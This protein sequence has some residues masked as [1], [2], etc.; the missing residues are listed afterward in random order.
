MQQLIKPSKLKPGDKVAAITLSWGGP[1]TFPYRFETGKQ[2][3]ES[4]FGLQV[5]PTKHALKSADWIYRN[6]KARAD[7]LMNAFLDPSIK[8]IISNNPKIF[9]GYSDTTVTHFMCLKAGLSSFYGPAVLTAFAENMVMH[10]YT[11][12]GIR[13]TLFSSEAIGTIPEN[14]QGWTT[15]VLDWA[16]QDNQNKQRKLH[17]PVEW[18]FIGN[19]DHT[20]KGRLIGGCLEVLEFIKSTSLWSEFSI[21]DQSIFFIETSE[22]GIE[23]NHVVRFMRNLATQG[24]LG[25]LKGILFS[26]PGGHHMTQERFFEYDQALLKVFEEFA[27]PMIPIVTRMDFGHSDPMWTLPYGVLTEINPIAKTVTIL[28]NS[29]E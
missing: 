19:C 29:V 24:I 16:N 27:L 14:R 17:P 26:K 9:M 23:P 2:R 3:L 4:I 21:W 18:N 13:K 25:K 11:I 5:V 1:G 6:P 7:D 10:D 15:E 22:E 20:C 12:T 28:E 8:G